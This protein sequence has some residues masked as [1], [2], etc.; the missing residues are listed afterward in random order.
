MMNI[1]LSIHWILI[2]AGWY[3]LMGILHDIFVI[4]N[5]KGPY[6]R[7]L[8]RLLM[9]GHVL[10]LSGIILAICYFMM[11][12]KI[13]YAP[14]IALIVGVGMLVYCFMIFPFLKS[15]VTMFISVMVVLVALRLNSDY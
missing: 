5:H 12:N 8:L 1:I 9:D 4:K 7:E 6:D 2:S 13:Q 3:F 10:M 14:W 15:F 11:M